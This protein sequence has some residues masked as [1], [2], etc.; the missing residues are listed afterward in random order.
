[1]ELVPLKIPSGWQVDWNNFFYD[2][3]LEHDLS[4][5]LLILINQTY[6]RIIDLGWYPAS[7]PSGEYCIVV[8]KL[9]EGVHGLGY[10]SGPLAYFKSKDIHSIQEKLNEFMAEISVGRL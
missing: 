9:S 8:A 2:G 1:M 4:E 5:N 10:W 7:K 6:H 3:I